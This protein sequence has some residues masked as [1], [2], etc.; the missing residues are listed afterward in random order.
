MN[1]NYDAVN[2]GMWFGKLGV[3]VKDY[4]VEVIKEGTSLVYIL[5]LGDS[6]VN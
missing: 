4:K 6:P 3:L 5:R 1:L 2:W